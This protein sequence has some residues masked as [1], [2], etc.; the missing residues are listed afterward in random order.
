MR[1]R[2]AKHEETLARA[3][4]DMIEYI[5]TQETL[6]G[7]VIGESE[8]AS[9]TLAMTVEKREKI[10]LTTKAEVTSKTAGNLEKRRQ[11]AARE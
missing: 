11:K 1:L 6:G 5:M 4:T 7:T 9:V 2:I 8:Q 10:E 3:G